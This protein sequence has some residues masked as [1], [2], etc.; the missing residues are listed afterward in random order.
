MLDGMWDG[1]FKIA[2]TNNPAWILFDVITNSRYGLGN[3]L[4][5]FSCDKWTL[6]DIARYCDVMVDDGF[7][8]KEPLYL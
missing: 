2:W 4:G 6:Y 8:G 1:T 3:M 7:G 5:S